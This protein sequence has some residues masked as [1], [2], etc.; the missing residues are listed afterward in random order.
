MSSIISVHYM[1]EMFSTCVEDNTYLGLAQYVIKAH[2][3]W[4]MHQVTFFIES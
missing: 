3:Y 1:V 4:Q 2:G